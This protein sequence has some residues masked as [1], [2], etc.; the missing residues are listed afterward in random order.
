ML[1][2]ALFPTKNEMSLPYSSIGKE[3]TK[4]SG[5]NPFRYIRKYLML[6]KIYKIVL[7][8]SFFTIYL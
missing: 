3:R 6:R 7:Q 8:K 5:L 1:T 4:T 2:Q